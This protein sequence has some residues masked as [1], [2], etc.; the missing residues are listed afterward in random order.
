[1]KDKFNINRIGLLLK[2]DFVQSRK[3]LLFVFAIWELLYIIA[4]IGTYYKGGIIGETFSQEELYSIYGTF[5]LFLYIAVLISVFNSLTREIVNP[6]SSL[7]Y[8]MIPANMW[9]KYLVIHLR[10]IIGLAGAWIIALVNLIVFKLILFPSEELILYPELNDSLGFEYIA[11]CGALLT[12]VLAYMIFI[13]FFMTYKNN[14]F[15]KSFLSV[16]AIMFS[17]AIY[18]IIIGTTILKNI[19]SEAG[20]KLTKMFSTITEASD[21]NDKLTLYSVIFMILVLIPV[22]LQT[23]ASYYK[24]KEKEI[25]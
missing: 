15:L 16:L 11:V 7:R 24:L 5:N 13:N 19:V 23:F 3:R 17:Y 14:N 4:N 2:Y 22:I 18:V 1:M 25:R 20:E 12:Q 6:S 9:E 10:F 8:M 21:F